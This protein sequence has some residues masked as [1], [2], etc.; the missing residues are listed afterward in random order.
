MQC[1]Q[2][3][4][5]QHHVSQPMAHPAQGASS[6]HAPKHDH[7]AANLDQL[8]AEASSSGTRPSEA[9]TAGAADSHIVTTEIARSQS[10][11]YEQ[12][13]TVPGSREEPD[14]PSVHASQRGLVSVC[15]SAHHPDPDPWVQEHAH[16]SA[17]TQSQPSSHVDSHCNALGIQ[18][19]PTKH[20]SLCIGVTNSD[21]S[22]PAAV[23]PGH[24]AT[25]PPMQH[26]QPLSA[27]RVH[28]E[29]VETQAAMFS[30]CRTHDSQ[31][32]ADN[33]SDE[34]S[35]WGPESHANVSVQLLAAPPTAQS[36][37][38]IEAEPVSLG[39]LIRPQTAWFCSV[40]EAGSE[41][42]SE[43]DTAEAAAAAAEMEEP[44]MWEPRQASRWQDVTGRH[45]A[46]GLT[47]A[48]PDM[49]D[50]QECSG[51]TDPCLVK[52]TCCSPA[53]TVTLAGK[54]L[55]V[56]WLCKLMHNMRGAIRHWSIKASTAVVV[57][58]D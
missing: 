28:G 34:S 39:Q 17:D 20:H 41:A 47:L 9:C 6:R 19:S 54:T 27:G 10:A 56:L 49:Q 30:S 42:E 14:M 23:Q 15:G 37:G 50:E 11:E 53:M 8:P 18:Q 32:E 16:S 31:E 38:E 26:S 12:C 4:V 22:D 57:V 21:V 44:S 46:L 1:Q 25:S 52:W 5:A 3:G 51:D 58:Q 7:S 43:A 13:S 29:C 48:S 40:S 35:Q 33:G 2:Q 24:L 36:A 45:N 55:A